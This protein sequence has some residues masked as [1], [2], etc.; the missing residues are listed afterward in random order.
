MRDRRGLAFELEHADEIDA[1]RRFGG[2]FEHAAVD[3][4]CA[5]LRPGDVALD[6]GANIG[7]F[8][9]PM[10]RAVT[11][12]GRVYAFEPF[13][14]AR[15]RL[16]RSLELNRVDNVEVLA[17]AVTESVGE[18]ELV[19]YGPGYESW[20]T[21]APRQIEIGQ[22]TVHAVGRANVPSTTLD[23][24]SGAAG[25]EH[26]ALAK[27]DVE[28]AEGLVLAGATGLLRRGAIDVLMVEASDNTLEAAGTS[29]REMLRELERLQL[30]VF[31]L[32]SDGDLVAV[33]V[34][35]RV[36]W[37]MQLVAVT[38]TGRER[39][40]LSGRHLASSA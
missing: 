15:R 28:G 11:E 37:L 35:G 1:F 4:A 39:L 22:G 12:S 32:G 31:E 16:T 24:F 40:S 3:L 10:A 38:A 33:R 21:V 29:V 27:I 23:A 7:A 17:V 30:E 2:H 18:V 34:G 26:V 8:T 6:I 36:D 20:S 5:L 13:A 14:P 25:L 9:V 19:D